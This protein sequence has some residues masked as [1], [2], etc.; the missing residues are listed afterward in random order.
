MSSPV[1]DRWA[2]EL[3]QFDIKFQHIH[4]KP[5][6]VADA[7]SRLKTLGLYKDN[8]NEDDPSTIDVVVDNIIRKSTLQA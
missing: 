4:S 2:L 6:A 7:I 1:L 5:N 3:Q 8:D